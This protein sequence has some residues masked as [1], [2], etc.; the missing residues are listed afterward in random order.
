VPWLTGARAAVVAG[1]I[2]LYEACAL[3]VPTIAV[4]IVRAQRPAVRAMARAGAVVH[5]PAAPPGPPAAARVARQTLALLDGNETRGRLSLRARRLVDGH[6]AARVAAV[7]RRLAA[8]E[9][10]ESLLA[11]IDRR[12]GVETR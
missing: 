4:P 5:V 11:A 6:G 3:G 10:L 7:L 1:G 2:T 8:G 9:P 12:H